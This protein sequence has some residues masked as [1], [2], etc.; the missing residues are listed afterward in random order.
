MP[1]PLRECEKE[2]ER[3]TLFGVTK[4]NWNFAENS[5]I[6][7][8]YTKVH[9]SFEQIDVSFADLN[10]FIT[11]K[12]LKSS[13]VQLPNSDTNYHFVHPNGRKIKYWLIR[14]GLDTISLLVMAHALIE[15]NSKNMREYHGS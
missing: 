8:S 2:S 10:A 12:L 15:K 5:L 6:L 14:L 7:F 9:S 4:R 13:A 1:P 11:L 3:F